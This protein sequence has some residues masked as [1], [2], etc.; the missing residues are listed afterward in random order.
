MVLV[1]K[2]EGKVTF[3]R[4]RHGG[5]DNIKIYPEEMGW[6]GVDSSGPQ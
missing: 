5:N 2:T 3:E 4:P 1:E 6:D